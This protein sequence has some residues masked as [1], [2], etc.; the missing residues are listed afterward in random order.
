[1]LKL[2]N[3]LKQ[4]TPF[5]LNIFGF[6]RPVAASTSTQPISGL[7]EAVAEGGTE[8]DNKGKAATGGV[9]GDKN[10]KSKDGEKQ[11]LI[12]ALFE[13]FKYTL[14]EYLESLKQK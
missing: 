12:K 5:C 7:D 8:S 14:P 6:Y 11:T 3:Y 9:G 10:N 13:T 2:V 4:S 1:M